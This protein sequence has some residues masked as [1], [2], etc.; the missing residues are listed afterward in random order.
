MT[1][2]PDDTPQW[3]ET[4]VA[5]LCHE[6][7]LITAGRFTEQSTQKLLRSALLAAYER[8]RGEQEEE[9][10]RLKNSLKASR[11]LYVESM[12]IDVCRCE[13][14]VIKCDHTGCRCMM[15]GKLERGISQDIPEAT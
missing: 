6:L 14:P 13:S 9:V 8:G 4:K 1:S 10:T 11:A 5:T 2:K 12:T 3:L 15:C 7:P